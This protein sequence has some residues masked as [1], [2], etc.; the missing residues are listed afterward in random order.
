MGSNIVDVEIIG[1]K[2]FTDL[3]SLSKEAVAGSGVYGGQH[4]CGSL[5]SL[6]YAFN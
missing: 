1:Y 3:M 4:W 5:D 2:L 6:I